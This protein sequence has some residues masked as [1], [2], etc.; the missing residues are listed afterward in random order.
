MPEVKLTQGMLVER[1][2][3]LMMLSTNHPSTI[4]FGLERTASETIVWLRSDW[5]AERELTLQ[6]FPGR[7]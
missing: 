5:A 3:S 4:M 2:F 7:S 1:T 6:L